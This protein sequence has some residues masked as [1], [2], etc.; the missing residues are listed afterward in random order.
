M[1]HQKTADLAA[2]QQGVAGQ[3]GVDLLHAFAHQLVDLGFLR[4]VGV[5]GIRQVAPLG[6]VANRVKVDVDEHADLLAAI[7]I[8]HHFLDVREKLELVFDI[9]GGKHGAVVGT[10]LQAP[11]VFHAVDDLQ[12]PV[13]VQKT[14]VAGVVPAVRRQH[15]G[16]GCRVLVVLLEQTG[17]P[18]QD[19]AVVGDLDLHAADRHA[20]G[21]GAGLV[22][23]LQADKHGGFGRAIELF[24]VDADGAVEAE[25]VRADGLA[26]RVGHAHPRKPQVVAQWPVHQQVAGRVLDAVQQAHRLAVHQRRADAP[27]QGHAAGKHL[28]LEGAGVFHAD[29]DAG[30]QAFKNARRGKVV[31]RADFFEIDGDGAGRLG[32]VDDIAAHQP[33]RI[34]E[35]VLP[36]PGR[37]QVGQHLFGAGQLVE[38]G[39]GAGAV[40]QRAVRV[41]HALGV[42]GGAGGEEHGR[43]MAGLQLGHPV[44]KPARLLAHE[45][46][47]SGQQR[48]VGGQAGLAVA[49]QAARVVVVDAFQRRA[50]RADLQQ[51]VHLLLVFHHGKAHFCVVQR[52]D[53]LS[54]HRVLVQRHRNGAQRLRCQHGGVQAWPVGADQHQV[55][56]A[57]QACQVQ[58]GRN[59]LDLHRQ[60]RPAVRL[61]DAVFLFA[62]RCGSG[63]L[64]GVLEQQLRKCGAHSRFSRK[65]TGGLQAMDALKA[66]PVKPI[67]GCTLTFSCLCNDNLRV[68]PLKAKPAMPG[69]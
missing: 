12:V 58:A 17:R 16:G 66:G 52:K 9:L 11:H 18:D 46:A 33:L 43:H 35:D 67:L 61:P 21:V 34:A 27:G 44:A 55:L 26:R 68:N 22:V 5:A 30:Q 6:P 63:A 37:R 25:Q 39:A 65:G 41:H 49:A 56:A 24:E 53:A 3:V 38:L 7:P 28:A 19:L 51:L 31:G 50:L 10:A 59:L 60:L 42:A 29:G 69:L 15:F 54:G 36:D 48:I 8:G 2:R 32:A 23:G 47:A 14:G 45:V 20:H 62:Q 13:R 40:D 4:Q 57:L 64:G 1:Q